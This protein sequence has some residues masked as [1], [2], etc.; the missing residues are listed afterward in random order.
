MY[1]FSIEYNLCLATM[2]YLMWTNVG[3]EDH[4]NSTQSD[5]FQG[6]VSTDETGREEVNYESNIVIRADCHASNKGLFGGIFILLV[7]LVM[8]FMFFISLSSLPRVAFYVFTGQEVLLAFLLLVTTIV[9]YWK[10]CRLDLDMTSIS[11]SPSMDLILLMVPLPCFFISYVMSMTA[12]VMVSLPFSSWSPWNFWRIA[13]LFLMLAQ[14][15]LQTIFIVDSSHRC[16]QSKRTRFKKPGRE[17]I[18][19]SILLNVTSWIVYTFETKAAESFYPE[20]S[21][22]GE[23]TWMIASHATLPLMLFY[24]FHA[25]VCLADIWKFAYERPHLD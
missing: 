8:M 4:H 13:L 17:M 3:K 5:H 15:I 20:V 14:V 12:E 25:S 23:T 19:F 1:P 2:W 7:N 21:F 24:R 9:G 22:Y 18:T 16:S 11:Q 6:T 10:T